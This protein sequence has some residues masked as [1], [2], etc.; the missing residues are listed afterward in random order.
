MDVVLEHGPG[1]ITKLSQLIVPLQF[2]WKL[3]LSCTQLSILCLYLRI[4]PFRWITWSSYATVT[5]IVAW[6]V[7]TI[8]TGCLICL[9][10]AFNW[11]KTVAGG[12]CGNQVT[13]FT[14]TGIIN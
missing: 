7:A 14:V 4:F 8:L 13:S 6:T 9:P 1:P 2:L 3:S 11:D 5:I 10:F 12:S